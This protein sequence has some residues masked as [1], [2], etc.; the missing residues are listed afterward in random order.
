M[1]FRLRARNGRP[2]NSGLVT[3]S[4]SREFRPDTAKKPYSF[5]FVFN[6]RPDVMSTTL[7]PRMPSPVFRIL[8]IFCNPAD[9]GIASVKFSKV[10]FLH[11]PI[12]AA[13]CDFQLCDILTC[14]NADEPVQ[15]L[16]K[17]RNSK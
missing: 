14:I 12:W 3:L 8:A 6:K 17:L 1:A 15:P 10:V 11:V 16:F 9:T 5:F 2:L 4:F 7:H 13:T